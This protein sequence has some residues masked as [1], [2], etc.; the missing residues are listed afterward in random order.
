M[1]LGT[2][3]IVLPLVLVGCGHTKTFHK[4]V[5]HSTEWSGDAKICNFFGVGDGGLNDAGCW[6]TEE[7]GLDSDMEYYNRDDHLNDHTYIMDV[8]VPTDAYQRLSDQKDTMQKFY[9]TKDG[10]AHLLCISR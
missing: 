10:K 9:C 4:V 7:V 3:W 8:E 1:K 6:E 2:L 5:V